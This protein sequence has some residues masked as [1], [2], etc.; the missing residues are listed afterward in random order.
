MSIYEKILQVIHGASIVVI[1]LVVIAVAYSHYG[2][3]VMQ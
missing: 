1:Y 3:Q 2:P